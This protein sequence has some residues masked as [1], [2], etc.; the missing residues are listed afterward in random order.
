MIAS[1]S[2]PFSVVSNETIGQSG[3]RRNVERTRYFHES[4]SQATPVT[5]R[6]P[7]S[8]LDVRFTNRWTY[9]NKPTKLAYLECILLSF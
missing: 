1:P 4:A 9:L 6:I 7:L 3:L 8:D 5:A 2:S